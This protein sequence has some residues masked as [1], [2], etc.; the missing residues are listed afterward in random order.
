MWIAPD[1]DE[2]PKEIIDLFYAEASQDGSSGRFSSA[3]STSS[4]IAG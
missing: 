3:F 2:T 1:F 4:G